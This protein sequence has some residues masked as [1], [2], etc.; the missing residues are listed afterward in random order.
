MV[1]WTAVVGIALVALGLVLTPGPNMI[2]LVSRTLA[3]GRTAGLVSLLGVAVGFLCYLVGSAV[4]LTALFTVVPILYDA[5]RLL[6]AGYLLWLAWQTVRAGK[7][8]LFTPAVALSPDPPRR[9]F[10][11]GLVTNLLNPKIAVLYVSLLPQFIDPAR[12]GV[13]SQGLL[14][15]LVQI[16][17]ALTMNCLIVLAAGA[18]ARWLTARPAW[19]RLQRWFMATVLGALALRLVTDRRPAVVS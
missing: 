4:G 8:S 3:Q 18:I 6:G 19:L 1:S 14:L 15:G 13:A 2:Y 11:M 12:G 17:I 10:L 16:S 9:L 7:P 5:V